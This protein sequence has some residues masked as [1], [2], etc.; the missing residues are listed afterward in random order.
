LAQ[1]T[2]QFFLRLATKYFG[3]WSVVGEGA[4]VVGGK[5]NKVPASYP[6]YPS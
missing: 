3:R 1:E 6:T 5:R 2:K 4:S